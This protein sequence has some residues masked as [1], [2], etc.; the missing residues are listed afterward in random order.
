M[1]TRVYVTYEAD[2]GTEYECRGYFT[3]GEVRRAAAAYYMEP[4]E[5]P[6]LEDVQVSDDGGATWRDVEDVFTDED[7]VEAI[8]DRLAEMGM[9]GR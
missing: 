6:T 2:D 4:P 8:R 5:P 9:E 1:G 7:D 3:P